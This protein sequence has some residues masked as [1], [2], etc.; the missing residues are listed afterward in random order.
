MQ[1]EK[2]V[3]ALL[4]KLDID[5]INFNDSPPEDAKQSVHLVA[6]E[7]LEAY[8]PLADMVDISAEVERL[9][10]C[11]SKMQTEYEGLKARLSSPKF[12]EKAHEDIVRS[13]QEKAA[14]AEEKINLTKHRLDF[15]KSTV[16]L[17]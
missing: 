13:V 9:T 3:L 5:N 11:L 7:G 14:E 8:L 4:S 1:E 12:I 6:S 15:L 10:K 16:V 17:S 2:E